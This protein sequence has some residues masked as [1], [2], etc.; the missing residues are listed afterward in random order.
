MA[1]GKKR[2]YGPTQVAGTDATA[3]TA[4]ATLGAVIRQVHIVNTDTVTRWAS[5]GLNGTAATAANCV[6]Y[7]LAIPAKGTYDWTGEIA[8]AG[9]D[10]I[11][12]IQESATACTYVIS[13]DG[14]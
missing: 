13:G 8:M 6:L 4:H 9:G 7:Q 2:L 3:Y 11:H 12:A 10:T 5:W 14:A 1:L